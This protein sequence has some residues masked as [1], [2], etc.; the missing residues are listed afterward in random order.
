MHAQFPEIITIGNAIYD[1][2]SHVDEAFLLQH[3]LVKG[4]M[5]LVSQ[6]EIN[7]LYTHLGPTVCVS[8][9]SAGNTAAAL[10]GLKTRCLFV[11]KTA[12]D[13]FGRAYLHD[14]RGAGV[15]CTTLPLGEE[16]GLQTAVCLVLVTPDGERTMLT[17]LGATT[18]L[19]SE[20]LIPQTLTQAFLVYGEAYLWDRSSTTEAC[21]T[22][23][24]LARQAGRATALSLSDSFCVDRHRDLF[25]EL[26]RAGALTLLFCNQ[27][28]IKALFQTSDLAT[29]VAAVAPLC[30]LCVVTLGQEGALCT[31]GASAPPLVVPTQPVE[32]LVDLT[33]AGDLFAAGFLHGYVRNAPLKACLA[34]GN[35]A[36]GAVITQMGAR[37]TCD[38][39]QLARQCGIHSI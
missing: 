21:R 3:H 15:L 37:V 29:A 4:S 16:E 35:A 32:N 12:S 27:H 39:P 14:L 22:A 23:F 1:I 33:G 26:L 28:E 10:A 34:L 36:A 38:L 19:T 5:R 8:G 2:L 25:L 30:P 31:Q 18:R 6:E 17:H 13:F 11:G 20:D 24:S 9:G 7:R